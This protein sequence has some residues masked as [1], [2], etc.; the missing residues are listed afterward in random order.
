MPPSPEEAPNTEGITMRL[1]YYLSVVRKENQ[2]VVHAFSHFLCLYIRSSVIARGS[3]RTT[4]HRSASMPA[5]FACNYYIFFSLSPF[6]LYLCLSFS[7]CPRARFCFRRGSASGHPREKAH[8]LSSNVWGL[9][10]CVVYPYLC[11]IFLSFFLIVSLSLSLSFLLSSFFFL[12]TL[13]LSF[14]TF[15]RYSICT[16]AE[17]RNKKDK[18]TRGE[19]RQSL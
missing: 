2:V 5:S 16:K 15:V 7:F 8:G 19:E 6:Y 18:M 17:N 4:P 13:A 12:S 9:Y 11:N 3:T 10:E 14:S 1:W